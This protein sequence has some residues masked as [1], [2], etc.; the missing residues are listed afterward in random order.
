MAVRAKVGTG[1]VQRK[2]P[3]HHK[4]TQGSGRG[5]KPKRGKKAYRGQGR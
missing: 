2:E 3:V 4:T 5:S 1:A